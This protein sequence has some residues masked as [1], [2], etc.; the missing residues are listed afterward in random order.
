MAVGARM[1]WGV[2]GRGH[3]WQGSKAWQGTCIARGHVW[4]GGMHGGGHVWWGPAQQGACVAGG[5]HG[6]G[7]CV[8]GRRSGHCSRQYAAYWNA[9][10]LKMCF[11][12]AENVH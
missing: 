9:F 7:A 11:D 10:L 8:R 1:A 12:V 5:V 6:R 3:A 2:C 4:Q